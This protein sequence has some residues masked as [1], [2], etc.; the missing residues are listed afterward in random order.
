[1][2]E[3]IS[4]NSCTPH[5]VVDANASG[6]DVP[7]EFARDGK[8]VLNV[9]WTATRNLRLTNEAV[10]FE[11]RFAG[12]SRIVNVPIHA[13]L[14]VYA[15]ETGQGIIF[16]DEDGGPAAPAPSPPEGTPPAQAGG[17]TPPSDARRARFKVV[18]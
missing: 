17:S 6:V 15:R 13:V 11:G 14:A 18:K 8:L 7:L 4:D 1:M 9:S 5:L 10:S 16:T 12:A 2:H 3:W